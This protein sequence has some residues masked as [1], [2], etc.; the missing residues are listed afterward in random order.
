M[1]AQTAL[2]IIVFIALVFSNSVNL[3]ESFSG[4]HS[5]SSRTSSLALSSTSSLFNDGEAPQ[6]LPRM[7][8][9]DLDNTLWTP[10]LYQIRK[11]HIQAEKDIRLFDAAR[12]ICDDL[13]MNSNS[14]WKSTTL[15]IAS[16][17]SKTDVAKRLLSEF[18]VSGGTTLDQVFPKATTKIFPGSKKTHFAELSQTT[19]IAL[20]DMIFF[21]DDAYMN[22]REIEKIGVLCVH[23]PRGMT[24]DLFRF[25]MTQYDEMKRSGMK[26]K[27]RT[28]TFRDMQKVGFIGSSSSDDNSLEF[29]LDDF[30][31]SAGKIKFYSPKKRFGFVKEDGN[32]GLEYFFHESKV[33]QGMFVKIGMKV[34]FKSLPDSSGRL[35]AAITKSLE[36][37]ET[38]MSELPC[39]SM[40][41]PF[42]SLLL[43]G[44]KTVETRNNDMFMNL[45]PGSQV[46][47]HCGMRDWKDKEAPKIELRRQ[48]YSDADIV[49]L[50]ALQPGEFSKGSIIGVLTI[51]KTWL[52][53][54]KERQSVDLERKVVA[55]YENMGKY[56]TEITGASWLRKPKRC[57]GRPGIFKA[58]VPDN[59]LPVINI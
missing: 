5:H 52:A 44:I 30:K 22:C 2:N 6:L 31:T 18:K 39:F 46:L 53:S 21:D 15:A 49:R 42:A 47:L 29:S 37:N 19:G 51:G 48:G 40:S 26:W 9:F 27:G 43:N 12:E 1:L 50:S 45:K 41:Q 14:F 10:E 59:C 54:D 57:K 7:M 11:S 28:L 4:M 55:K 56:C 16:R 20:S 38:S 17:T 24:L 58:K 25:A 23:C 35:A 8:V 32:E 33:P 36:E 34:Q 13:A 3:A